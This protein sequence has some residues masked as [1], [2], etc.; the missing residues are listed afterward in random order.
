MTLSTRSE[1][2]Q[3]ITLE[4][5]EAVAA[6]RAAGT[7]V[8]SLAAGAPDLPPPRAVLKW[9]S[10]PTGLTDT[11]YTSVRGLLPLRTAVVDFLGRTGWVGDPDRHVLVSNGAKQAL[12]CALAA[13]VDSGSEVI[14]VAPYWPSY[15]SMIT[16]LGGRMRLVRVSSAKET[17]VID[18]LERART[19]N[20]VA[21]VYSSPSNPTGDV[22]LT[23]E[24]DAILDWSRRNEIVVIADETY[25]QLYL[26][27]PFQAPSV[28]SRISDEDSVV[29]IGS[30]SKTFSLMGARV[31]WAAGSASIIDRMSTVQSHLSS[32]VSNQSQMLALAAMATSEAE[33]QERADQYSVRRDILF[34]AANALPWLT[35]TRPTGGLFVWCELPSNANGGHLARRLLDE[36]H[37]A[38]VPG[39]DFGIKNAIRL[40]YATSESQLN[41]AAATLAN[42]DP[43]F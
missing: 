13:T 8:V 43:H 30:A 6:R 23:S 5:Q 35:S 37:V 40:S 36:Q 32:N 27:G 38:V 7:P 22:L 15:R 29:Q 10:E 18:E 12:F 25:G 19:P 1:G 16:L 26:D 4:L 20:T 39:E 9:L 17:A 11:A 2:P 14:V 24:I 28:L 42:F 31:G 3:S 41:S 21:I 34:R 33:L